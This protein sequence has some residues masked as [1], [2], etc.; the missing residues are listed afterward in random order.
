M[1]KG[2]LVQ[3]LLIL[4]HQCDIHEKISEEQLEIED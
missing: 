4:R 1:E 2:S 3:D